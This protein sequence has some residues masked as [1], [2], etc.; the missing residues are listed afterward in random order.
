MIGPNQRV[1]A[2]KLVQECAA[3][4]APAGVS[5]AI[6]NLLVGLEGGQLAGDERV[7]AR[8]LRAGGSVRWHFDK[9]LGRKTAIWS[10]LTARETIALL[11][12][13]I[14]VKP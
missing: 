1:H 6:L 7:A 10:Q 8:C 3:P 12:L 11:G 2:E 5:I 13:D 9:K 4:D 14:P